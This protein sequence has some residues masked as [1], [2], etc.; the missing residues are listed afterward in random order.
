MAAAERHLNK[1]GLTGPLVVAVW[2]MDG[3][4]S[5]AGTKADGGWRYGFGPTSRRSLPGFQWPAAE[6]H[7]NKMVGL[8]GPVGR[9][10]HVVM[11]AASDPRNDLTHLPALKPVGTSEPLVRS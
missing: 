4:G 5:S 2:R 9:D 7:L 10:C 1:M 6:R 11:P 8:T 3:C